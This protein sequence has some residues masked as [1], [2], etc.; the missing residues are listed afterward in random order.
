MAYI[1]ISC[2][3]LFI[4]GFAL[5]LGKAFLPNSVAILGDMEYYPANMA[6]SPAAITTCLDHKLVSS[7]LL[8][9]VLFH[10]LLLN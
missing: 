7:C 10:R 4:I 2:I 8:S 6:L 5:G 3:I 1:S 9:Q